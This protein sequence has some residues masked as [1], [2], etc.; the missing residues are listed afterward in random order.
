VSTGRRFIA[1]WDD[2]AG[3]ARAD[4]TDGPDQRR[5]PT[6]PPDDESSVYVDQSRLRGMA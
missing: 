6:I 2:V 3:V 1:G 4:P 5:Y